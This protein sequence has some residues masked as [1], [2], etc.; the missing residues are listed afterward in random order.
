MA[1][2]GGREGDGRQIKAGDAPSGLRGGREGDGRQVQAGDAP[3]GL[4]AAGATA[5]RSR[6]ATRHPVWRPRGDGRQVRAGDAPSGPVQVSGLG[7]EPAADV[8]RTARWR[9]LPVGECLEQL[10]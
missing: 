3:S 10:R 4:A 6:P 8:Q 5:D 2:R 1:L 9:Q 7:A